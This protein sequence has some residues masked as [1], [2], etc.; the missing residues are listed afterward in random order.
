MD[1]ARLVQ[2]TIGRLH[3]VLPTAVLAAAMRPA[4]E[5]RDLEQRADEIVGILRAGGANMG[6]RSGREGCRE[7]AR[8]CWP[9]AASSTSSA[10][11]AS[12]CANARS[13]ATTHA[14][15][16]TSSLSPRRPVRTH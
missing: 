8:R 7:A 2:D 5:Q 15:S 11:A 3:K 16:S 10:A 6:V 4:I 12:A 13:C 1:L 14:R 9:I